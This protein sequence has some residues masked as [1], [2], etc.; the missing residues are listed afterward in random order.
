[1][2]DSH[3]RRGAVLAAM[4]LGTVL[5]AACTPS[6]D[7]LA[8]EHMAVVSRYCTECHSEAERSG[9]LVL[10][11][12]DLAHPEA[13]RA[14]WEKVVHKLRAGL[15]PPPGEP[16]PGN[17]AISGLVSYLENTLD[18]AAVKPL[19]PP[20]RRLNRSAY[21]NAVRDLLGFPIDVESLLPTE[22]LS[23]G[24]DNV[25]DTLKTS[26]LLLER[27]LT[28]GLRVAATAVGDTKVAPDRKSTRLNS[29]H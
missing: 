16:R 8:A 22:N 6:K 24:F 29:S 21:G 20:V 4:T 14:K 13:Q 26:P 11:R 17:E 23:E 5:L 3:A 19:G 10:E 15:M 28:V 27:Y 7:K 1:M 9:G 18:S 25:S 2:S 12:P